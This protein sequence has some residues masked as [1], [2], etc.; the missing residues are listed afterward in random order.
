MQLA[1]F[2]SLGETGSCFS[3]RRFVDPQIGSNWRR[4]CQNKS[5]QKLIDGSPVLKCFD[6]PSGEKTYFPAWSEGIHPQWI[7]LGVCSLPCLGS[8]LI[9]EIL[10]SSLGWALFISRHPCWQP[11]ALCALAERMAPALMTAHSRE[12]ELLFHRN[13]SMENV[14]EIWWN[15]VMR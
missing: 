10:H 8:G 11:T 4:H 13:Y 6:F 9:P 3:Y 12:S 1:Y 15:C 7:D 2:S 5:H 14:N